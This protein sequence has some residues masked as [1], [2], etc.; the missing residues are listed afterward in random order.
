MCS[1]ACS[2]GLHG[3]L[4]AGHAQTVAACGGGGSSKTRGGAGGSSGGGRCKEGCRRERGGSIAAR[5]SSSKWQTG[6]RSAAAAIARA[7]IC[8]CR[9]GS[10]CSL[11]SYSSQLD[12]RKLA[13]IENGSFENL[14]DSEGCRGGGDGQG[15]KCCAARPNPAA[16]AGALDGAQ[17]AI[18]GCAASAAGEGGASRRS[19]VHFMPFAVWMVAPVAMPTCAAAGWQQRRVRG[20]AACTACATACCRRQC[21]HRAWMPRA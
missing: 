20:E 11:A 14:N 15:M 4:G 19:T 12:E 18:A 13:T 5:R 3:A 17:L 1:P 6:G 9:H 8:N 16:A 10:H 2:P 7:A 21:V